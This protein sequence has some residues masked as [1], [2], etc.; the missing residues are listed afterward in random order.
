M[1]AGRRILNS[2]V[3]SAVDGSLEATLSGKGRHWASGAVREARHFDRLSVGT[4]MAGMGLLGAAWVQQKRRAEAA[5]GAAPPPLPVEEDPA[6]ERDAEAM[7]LVRAMIAAAN[8]DFIIEE[9]ERR[10]ILDTCASM[11]LSAEDRRSLAAEFAMPM[12]L[13]LILAEVNTPALAREV[14]A[15]SV[16]VMAAGG[17]HDAGY[18]QDLADRLGIPPAETSGMRAEMG[19]P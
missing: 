4:A 10:A 8:A 18:L 14:Y 5:R 19:L 16:L 13:D 11:G 12:D 15:A 1:G 6:P 2:L 7:T 3:S 17:A 9:S